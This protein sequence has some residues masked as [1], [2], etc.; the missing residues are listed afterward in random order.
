MGA[1]TGSG[2][3]PAHL[4]T[5]FLGA[6]KTTL[7]NRILS[8]R[9][10][11]R[12]AVVVNEFGDVGID[13]RLVERSEEDLVEL[14][15]GCVCC[16]VRG[17]L[18]R[19]IGDLLHR[20]RRRFLRVPF[21]RLV[22]EASGLASP[23]P[24]LQTLRLDAALAGEVEPAAVLAVASAADLVRQAA[25]H[26]EVLEQLAHADR[27]VLGHVDRAS[28][29]EREAAAALVA[30]VNPLAE[31]L[32]AERGA[33]DVAALLAP[34]PAEPG[35]VRPAFRPSGH[36][37]SSGAAACALR[38]REELDLARVRMWLGFVAQRRDAVPWRLKGVLRCRGQARA[39]VVQGVHQWLEI[40]PGVQDPPEESTLVVIG[41]GL[42]SDELARGW[43]ACRARLDPG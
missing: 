25:E 42:D 40:A 4:L 43:Q 23:G 37:H 36:A 2:P 10:A 22:V 33:V 8:A 27:V 34:T 20:R 29:A 16:T 18:V 26:P 21:D 41:R 3:V 24:I 30:S 39:I 17:D 11:E 19:T 5:G 7:L 9:A 1:A 13:G 6:G 15:N 38:T 28:A 32:P 31:V 14:T 12:I 35:A